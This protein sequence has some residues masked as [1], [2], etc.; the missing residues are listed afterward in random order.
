MNNWMKAGLIAAILLTVVAAFIL[1]SSTSLKTFMPGG[2]VAGGKPDTYNATVGRSTGGG[3]IATVPTA[4]SGAGLARRNAGK[5]M[6]MPGQE[7]PP[8]AS[9]KVP[10]SPETRPDTGTGDLSAMMP[11]GQQQYPP[12]QPG[13]AAPVYNERPQVAT[14]V[15]ERQMPRAYWPWAAT[16]DDVPGVPGWLKWFVALLRMMPLVFPRFPAFF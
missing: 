14:P 6:T 16:D 13:T 15:P 4:I 5:N 8:T 9:R 7:F 12:Y 11:P 3:R 1:F 10:F 2:K